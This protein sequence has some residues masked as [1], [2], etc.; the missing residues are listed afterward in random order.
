MVISPFNLLLPAPNK[1]KVVSL[2]ADDPTAARLIS[3]E[4]LLIDKLKAPVVSPKVTV[5]LFELVMVVLTCS[6][7]VRDDP[8]RS[9]LPTTVIADGK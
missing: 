7:L 1:L 2:E 3:P 6:G 9:I 5:P 8:F 4:P